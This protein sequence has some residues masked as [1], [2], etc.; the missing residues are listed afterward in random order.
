MSEDP[1]KDARAP[2]CVYLV[3]CSD[4]TL[5][6]GVTTDISRRLAEHNR[7]TA[8][9]YTRGRRPVVLVSQAPCPDRA[10]ALVLEA[11]VKR[12]PRGKKRN[13]LEAHNKK[14]K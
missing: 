11:A 10:S 9:R 13:F 3:E 4:G 6:C 7:G 14:G 12:L 1:L 8:S 2:W 5:Y